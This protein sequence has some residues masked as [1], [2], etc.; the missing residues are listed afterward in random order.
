MSFEN[1]AV[2]DE[3]FAVGSACDDNFE[4]TPFTA[5][6]N[7]SAIPG[8]VSMSIDVLIANRLSLELHGQLL[9]SNDGPAL[10]QQA[11]QY[12][13][14]DSTGRRKRLSAMMHCGRRAHGPDKRFRI[15]H[16]I[17]RS[18]AELITPS[19][20]SDPLRSKVN[21]VRPHD[22]IFR[23]RPLRYGGDSVRLGQNRHRYRASP[24]RRWNEIM[25]ADN[26]SGAS[27]RYLQILPGQIAI[28]R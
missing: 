23:R 15:P 9:S 2:L 26:A 21:R 19:L 20:P 22:E 13:G 10:F 1:A 25:P 12:P 6:A 11:L 17:L 24:S 7:T 16:C 5:T 27:A 28:S 3:F 14:C 8:E 4:P 18:R